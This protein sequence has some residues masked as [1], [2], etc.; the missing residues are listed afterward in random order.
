MT[1][2]RLI[3]PFRPLRSEAYPFARRR[4]PL[5]HEVEHPLP[6]RLP[7][8]FGYQTLLVQRLD[9]EQPLACLVRVR[10][11]FGG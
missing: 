11:G 1:N 4:D 2:H 10:V 6:Q 7:L 8:L 9:I 3:S 5:H